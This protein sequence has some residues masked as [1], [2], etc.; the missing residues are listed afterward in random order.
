MWKCKK[1]GGE[2]IADCC[3]DRD[4]ILTGV[5]KDGTPDENK[6]YRLEIDINTYQCENYFNGECNA[7]SINLEKI[8]Y[9]ED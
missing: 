4:T 3:Y 6:I 2:I 7:E 8:A 9:W 1:C 5:S